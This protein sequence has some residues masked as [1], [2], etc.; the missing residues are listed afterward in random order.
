MKTVSHYKDIATYQTKDGSEIRELMHP[1]NHANRNQSLAEARVA[2]GQQTQLHRHNQTEEI[3]YITQGEGKMRLGDDSFPV[4]TGDCVCISPGT[5]HCIQNTGDN[6]LIILC[7]CS[8]AY[9]HNDTE[10]LK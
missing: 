1:D 9:S 7:C 8:P 6:E 2:A 3:Y 4:S 5:A 10:L